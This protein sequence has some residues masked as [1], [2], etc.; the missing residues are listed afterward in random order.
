MVDPIEKIAKAAR[1]LIVVDQG[2]AGRFVY[3]CR[4]VRPEE[5]IRRGFLQIVEI[6]A[7]SQAT[8]A[9][10][11]EALIAQRIADAPD[12]AAR[13]AIRASI[14]EERASDQQATIRK[15]MADPDAAKEYLAQCEAYLM[16]SI[17]AL[18]LALDDA[19]EGLQAPGTQVQDVAQPLGEEAGQPVYLRPV[20]YTDGPTDPAKG[21][22]GIEDL[23]QIAR[24]KIGVWAMAASS[25]AEEL[26]PL[27]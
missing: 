21:Q 15:I 3:G 23:G 5:M 7:A 18:G 27:R 8:N 17:E 25:P 13:E 14:S 20:R 12:D 10:M 24:L 22:I 11:E 9:A 16:A 4:R 6:A 26:R 2:A 1:R 19:P